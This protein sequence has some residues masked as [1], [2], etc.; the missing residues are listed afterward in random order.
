MFCDRRTLRPS[1]RSCSSCTLDSSSRAIFCFSSSS[2]PVS[3]RLVLQ[4]MEQ[5]ATGK[6][7]LFFFSLLR[8]QSC[9]KMIVLVFICCIYQV[10]VYAPKQCRRVEFTRAC[11]IRNFKT[12]LERVSPEETKSSF[13]LTLFVHVTVI[14]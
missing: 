5:S 2:A 8:K 11:E 10:P 1:P 12:T 6:H 4:L 7:V 13:S 14:S 9:S 3:I